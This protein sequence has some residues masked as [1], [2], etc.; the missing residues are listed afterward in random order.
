M[1]GH[2]AV[3]LLLAGV[4]AAQ[5]SDKPA[6]QPSGAQGQQHRERQGFFQA[7]GIGGTIAAIKSDGLT[8]KTTD[9]KTVTVKI[10]PETRFRKDRQEAGFSDFKVGDMVMVGAE[11]VGSDGLIARFVVSRSAGFADGSE[12]NMRAMREDMGKKI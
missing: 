12:V 10:T 9:G 6:D 2:F 3:L 5:T 8:V 1:K 11:P 7:H 4:C